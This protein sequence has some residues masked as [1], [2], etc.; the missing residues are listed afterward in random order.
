MDI[1]MDVFDNRYTTADE[2]KDKFTN[3]FRAMGLG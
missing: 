1:G 3:F 2:I